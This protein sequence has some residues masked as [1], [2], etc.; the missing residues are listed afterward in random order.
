M[1]KSDMSRYAKRLIQLGRREEEG[2]EKKEKR[3]SLVELVLSPSRIFTEEQLPER[4]EEAGEED[5]ERQE[6]AEEYVVGNRKFKS[7]NGGGRRRRLSLRGRTRNSKSVG[8]HRSC[9]DL[10]NLDGSELQE[11]GNTSLRGEEK[12]RQG[13]LSKLRGKKE[14]G[15][16]EEEMVDTVDTNTASVFGGAT[17]KTQLIDINFE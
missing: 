14:E 10:A 7:Y 4:E 17:M 2:Q 8:S 12:G 6:S 9:P 15:L 13:W 16:E 3:R 5:E 11:D 1:G